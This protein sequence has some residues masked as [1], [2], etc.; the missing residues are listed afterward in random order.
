MIFSENRSPLFRIM[1]FLIGHDL[2]GKPVPTFPDHALFRTLIFVFG[3]GNH[4]GAG[5]PAIE[6]YVAAAF[7]AERVGG[8]L[9]GLAADRTAPDVAGPSAALVA[10]ALLAA[11]V[12]TTPNPAAG[13]DGRLRR[14]QH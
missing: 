5:K 8:L 14:L 9:R 6:I 4:V 12:L 13:S 10:P 11:R 2:F 3:A 1:P 7:G